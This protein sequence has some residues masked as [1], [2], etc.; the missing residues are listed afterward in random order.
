MAEMR[1]RYDQ[2]ALRARWRATWKQWG[3]I[4]AAPR[5][6]RR[7]HSTSTCR[8]QPSR[9]RSMLG[10]DA[11]VTRDDFLVGAAGHPAYARGTEPL[12]RIVFSHERWATRTVPIA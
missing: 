6:Y 7:G 12:H 8:R 3:G 11:P 1:T 10:A 5:L 2:R 4:D 9:I